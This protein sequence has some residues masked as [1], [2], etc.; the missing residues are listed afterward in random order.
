MRS[1]LEEYNWLEGNPLIQT[2]Y[3]ALWR[4]SFSRMVY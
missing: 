1:Q 4:A 2:G 3:L